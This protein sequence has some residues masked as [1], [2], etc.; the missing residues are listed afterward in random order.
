MS[1]FTEL[2]RRNVIRMAG[3]Y[4][5]G[6]WLVLQ[7]AETL[8]PIFDTPDWVLKAMV[9]M[10]A[11]GFLPALALSWIFELTPDGLKRESEVDPRNS[12]K[13]QTARKLDLVVILLL[14]AV[15]AM[16]VL[17]PTWQAPSPAEPTSTEP[18]DSVPV[19]AV[20]APNEAS[21]A[22]L[23][24]ADLSPNADQGYFSDGMAE[25]ILNVLVKVRG[26]Q[27]A[28]RT[29]SFSFKGQE[30]LGIPAIAKQLSVRHVLEGS[31]RRSGETLRITAQLIDA[32][33]DRHL[34]SETF[35][36]P[37]TAEN[38]FAIQDEIAKAIVAALVDSLQLTQVGHVERSIATHD[39]STYD[40]F[41]RA[42][43]MLQSR[44]QVDRAAQLLHRV[45]EQDPQFAQAWAWLA[46]ATALHGD[47]VESAATDELSV[48]GLKQVERALALDPDNALARAARANIRL[49]MAE[50][51]A[52]P[53][54][55]AAII[56]DL[57]T[58]LTLDPSNGNTLNWLGL[59]WAELGETSRALDAFQQCMVVDPLLAPC[60]ENEYETLFTLGRREESY[61]H[62]LDALSTGRVTDQYTNFSLLAA[63]EQRTTFLFALG[64]TSWLPDWH[65]QEAIYQAY[66]HPE[67][68]H[69]EL[70][71]ALR[72]HVVQIENPGSYLGNL[73]IPLGIHDL[74]RPLSLLT[75][76]PDFRSYRQSAQFM[77]HKR[78]SGV[79]DY[80]QTHG[81]PASCRAIEPDDFEC[82]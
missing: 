22:V 62:F 43:D 34:W 59:T 4:L 67:D 58:S 42:R 46:T 5:V 41:L 12:T 10:L 78:Q 20:E 36:R 57:Q 75:W 30:S 26:L 72:R 50:T 47:Y 70:I 45:V 74:F 19:A 53:Q 69:T 24:F 3:L 54:D 8:L 40:L 51:L 68:D 25:E 44:R 80:W 71:D 66:R 73:L 14:V 39:L 37:L 28:S 6:A 79:L 9:V 2:K 61:Q 35:D 76:G 33:S 52:G 18:I 64:Q 77:D 48:Q 65:L 23:P 60:V 32:E 21:I 17:K 56:S 38:V 1:F 13:D 31:V 55:M 29:S 49:Q 82:D 15:G 11:I 16:V 27:V 81:F 63:F 7:V